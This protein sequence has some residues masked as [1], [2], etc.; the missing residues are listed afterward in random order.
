M[1]AGYVHLSARDLDEAME[2]ADEKL[3]ERSILLAVS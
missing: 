2:I 3:R 1:A